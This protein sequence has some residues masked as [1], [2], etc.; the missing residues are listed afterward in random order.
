[1]KL[2]YI[3]HQFFPKHYMGTERFTLDLARQMQRMGH[4]PTVVT[5][6]PSYE[7]D[8]FE[9]LTKGVLTK[10]Y[11]YQGVPVIAFKHATPRPG[12]NILDAEIEQAFEKLG[13]TSDVAH[14]SHPMRLSSIAVL[15]KRAGTPV[16]ITL[17]DSWLLCPR[18]ML[19]DHNRLCMGP[20]LGDK[21][22]LEYGPAGTSRLREAKS[23]FDMADETVVAS[24]FLAALFRSN[25]WKRTFQIVPHSIDY[26]TVRRSQNQ[27][28]GRITFAF[29][30]TIAWHKG[31]HVLVKAFRKVACPNARLRI[32]G[33]H[34]PQSDYFNRLLELA[35]GDER[36]QFMDAFA[37]QSLPKVM[38]DVSVI[39]IPSVYYEPYPLVMLISLAYKIP[40]IVS[41]IGGMP[42]VVKD[43]FNGFLFEPGDAAQLTNVI[44][45]IAR[46]PQVLQ[47][48]RTNIVSPRRTE[49]EALDYENIYRRLIH[50][51]SSDNRAQA[52]A[53][54]NGTPT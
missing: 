11:T 19:D 13:I 37:I 6:D 16:V 9:S 3:V 21:C 18:A 48:L 24:R 1:M 27:S 34:D 12:F 44:E 15:L 42:E 8:G 26:A 52:T 54:A 17:T 2:L 53:S 43:G 38:T 45:R 36:I 40:P 35:Q 33:S 14:V 46:E 47:E 51:E 10:S 25:G 29:I 32:Y 20:D 7:Q 39:V 50:Q 22:A 31:P 28:S 49:E 4:N 5:Y 30:G 23:L 41:N